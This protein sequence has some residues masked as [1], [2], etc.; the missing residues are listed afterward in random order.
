MTMDRTRSK[1]EK[2]KSTFHMNG[3]SSFYAIEYCLQDS[4]VAWY[5]RYAMP[6]IIAPPPNAAGTRSAL[7]N[8]LGRVRA[9]E[10]V[11]TE[12]TLCS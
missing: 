5:C 3:S 2:K 7:R 10:M 4:R 11:R 9:N 1:L 6:A 8:S 12:G